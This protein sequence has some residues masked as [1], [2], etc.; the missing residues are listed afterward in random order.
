MKYLFLFFIAVLFMSSSLYAQKD[1]VTV[2]GYYESGFTYGTLNDAI[3]DVISNGDIN[4]TVFKLKPYDIYVLSKSIFMD[5]GQN[6][7]IVADFA[8]GFFK[9][10]RVKYKRFKII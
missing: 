5:V 2:V 3:D 4:N 1:T 6:L 8:K 7:E 9:S 10:K